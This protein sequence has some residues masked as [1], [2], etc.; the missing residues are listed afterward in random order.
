[1]STSAASF[2]L[3]NEPSLYSEVSTESFRTRGFAVATEPL[4]PKYPNWVDRLK[5][6]K[7]S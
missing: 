7:V 3:K 2:A 4:L 1:M 5:K 6:K